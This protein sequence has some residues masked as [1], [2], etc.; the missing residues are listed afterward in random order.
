ME[1]Q[2]VKPGI[3]E[4]ERVVRRQVIEEIGDDEDISK[5]KR[6]ALLQKYGVMAPRIDRRV[7]K[8]SWMESRVW[9]IKL[10]EWFQMTRNLVPNHQQR[11]S[12]PEQTRP[13]RGPWKQ[14][15]QRQRPSTPTV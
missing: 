1:E 14:R 9:K 6:V 11:K 3:S 12:N 2:Q 10:S 4:L 7:T 8:P 15:P 13:Q 5:D